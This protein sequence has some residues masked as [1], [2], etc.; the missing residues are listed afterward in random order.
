VEQHL[1]LKTTF[2]N[3][4]PSTTPCFKNSSDQGI[5][6]MTYLDPKCL[7]YRMVTSLPPCI[8]VNVLLMACRRKKQNKIYSACYKRLIYLFF[9]L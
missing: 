9:S 3:S 4:T 5:T 7:I 8:E 6:Q 1:L 2:D